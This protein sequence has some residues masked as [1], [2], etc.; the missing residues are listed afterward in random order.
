MRALIR[1]DHSKPITYTFTHPPPTPTTHPTSYI[2]RTH[3]AGLTRGELAW[4]EALRTAMPIPGYDFA[5]TIISCPKTT[6][7]K[8]GDK[9]YGFTGTGLEGNAREVTVALESELG[10]KPAR[11]SWAEAAAVPLSALTAYQALFVHGGLEPAFL[12]NNSGRGENAGKRVLVTAASGS[13]GIWAAQLARL[14]GVE[15]VGTCGPA[16]V[17]FVGGLGADVV[18]LDYAE[19]DVLAWVN[20]DR[21]ARGFDVVVDC[22]GGQTLSEA[23]KSVR[24]GGIVVGVAEPPDARR[25][26]EGVEDGVRGIWFVVQPDGDQLG[27]VTALI[28]QGRCRVVVDSVFGLEQ[29]RDAFERV[30]SGHA[31][32]RVVLQVALN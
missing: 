24:R 32:G 25:P 6:G 20:E 11:L 28:E 3:T 19:T 5:G 14:A 27:E 26:G 8:P 21:E 1:T 4:P 7:F 15:V 29:F 23:F 18:V 12:E 10:H 2:I 16:N 22:V 9:V 17:Q 31:R 13:V 30:E